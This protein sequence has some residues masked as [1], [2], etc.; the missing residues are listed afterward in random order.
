MYTQIAKV[1]YKWGVRYW[2]F[3]GEFVVDA[4][5][6]C[7]DVITRNPMLAK[8]FDDMDLDELLGACRDK[9]TVVLY[10]QLEAEQLLRKLRA[11]L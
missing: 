1:N 5:D 3:R 6:E 10:P 11:R 2:C 9:Y 7:G 4:Y 8:I